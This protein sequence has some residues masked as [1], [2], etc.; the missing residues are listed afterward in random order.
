[1][2]ASVPKNPKPNAG[3]RSWECGTQYEF[4][5]LRTPN[6]MRVS[7]LRT[8]NPMRISVLRNPGTQ[9]DLAKNERKSMSKHPNAVENARKQIVN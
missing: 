5:F 1:M 4:P 6:P 7:F 8:Q 3:F 9:V 2:R